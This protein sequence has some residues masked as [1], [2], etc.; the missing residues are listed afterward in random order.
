MPTWQQAA[1]CKQA[2]TYLLAYKPWAQPKYPLFGSQCD[3]W[4]YR[5]RVAVRLASVL[6]T[7][8]QWTVPIKS[9]LKARQDNTLTIIIKSAF[10]TSLTNKD[11]YPYHIPTL[12]VS[13]QLA[14]NYQQQQGTSQQQA[15]CSRRYSQLGAA[16]GVLQSCI[17]GPGLELGRGSTPLC[18][19]VPSV[20]I[21]P[22]RS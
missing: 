15:C 4:A 5:L 18:V 8:R 20:L 3:S 9:Y 1:L 21:C 19:H 12:Y 10:K 14:F 16:A 13:Y 22:E 11:A 7:C 2:Y 6:P 17:P